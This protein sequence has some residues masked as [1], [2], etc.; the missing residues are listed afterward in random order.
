MK[1][2]NS[3]LTGV[4]ALMLASCTQETTSV[5]YTDITASDSTNIVIDAIMSRRSIRKYQDKAVEKSKLDTLVMCGINAPSGMNAQ[6]WEIRVVNDPAFIN[7]VTEVFKKAN[8]KQVENDPNFVNMFRNAPAIIAVASPAD[9][10][11]LDCGMLGENMMIAANA[12]GLGTCCLGGPTRFLESDPG[13]RPYYEKLQLP[14]GYRL[15]FI[16]A[17]GYPDE[18]PEAKPRDESKV[19]FITMD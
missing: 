11:A 1:I 9:A 2:K 17:V 19:K 13:A 16:L 8:P 6:P 14:E 18:A 4:V 10:G 5:T 15:Q 7:G 3:L 12:M